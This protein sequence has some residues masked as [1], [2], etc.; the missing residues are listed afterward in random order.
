MSKDEKRILKL[1]LI[2][3]VPESKRVEM[4][5]IS[6]GAKLEMS[7][8]PGYYDYLIKDYPNDVELPSYRQIDLVIYFI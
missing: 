2:K 6:S 8:N 1:L 3:G 7:N 4:W 5:F